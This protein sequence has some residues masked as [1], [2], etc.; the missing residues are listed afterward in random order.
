MPRDTFFNAHQRATVEAAMARMIPTDHEPGAREAGAIDFVERYLSGIAFIYA[1]P[2]GGGFET[3]TGKRADSW[4][5]RIDV[6]RKTYVEGIAALDTLASEMFRAEF[7]M[8]NEAQQDE[9]LAALER[10][11]AGG[12][13]GEGPALQQT[14]TETELAFVPLLA[15][16]T[17]QGF[18]SDPVYGG[19]K[20]HVGWTVIG[21]P[22]PSSLMEVFT[23]RYSALPW[24][25]EGEERKYREANRGE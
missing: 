14:L 24:F 15:M 21:F 8:L 6:L 12:G 2:G 25:A 22:G 20:G 23:G 13:D 11:Q 5:Q 17:R 4:R 1:K 10:G 18:Y 19:N 9:T 3:L 7:R 16:H